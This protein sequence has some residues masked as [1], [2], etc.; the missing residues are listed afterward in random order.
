MPIRVRRN[1][2]TVITFVSISFVIYWL[3]SNLK[4]T[5]DNVDPSADLPE[6]PVGNDVK[7]VRSPS[8]PLQ[9]EIVEINGTKMRKI[10]WHDYDAIAREEARTGWFLFV[11][12]QWWSISIRSTGPGEKGAGVEPSA[13]E[14]S[15][16]QFKRLYRENG[17]NAFI[18]DNISL[19]RSVKDIRHP[20]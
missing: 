13:Q 16:S 3:N 10:D 9:E 7:T 6:K 4:S 18:S 14:R 5:T 15:D 1:R 17:F 19:D 20:R 12:P 11:L 8:G 2:F